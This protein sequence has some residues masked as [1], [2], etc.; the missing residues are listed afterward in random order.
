MAEPSPQQ[1]SPA[2][3]SSAPP[4]KAPIG[5]AIMA[6]VIAAA[7]LFLHLRAMIMETQ[8]DKKV[9]ALEA[10]QTGNDRA[11][12]RLTRSVEV[13]GNAVTLLSDEQAD[14]TNSKL[15]H[16]RHGFAVSEL[17][18]E[19]QDTGVL[20]EGR[21]INTSSLR[22]RDATFRV[23]VGNSSKEITIGNL[24]PGSSS[25]FEAVLPNLALEN[26]RTASFSLVSSA[27]EYGR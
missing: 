4:S 11:Q 26:A 19:R 18:L 17:K 21:M 9:Q 7:A 2:P 12:G 5:I 1:E 13:L 15:Q 16:L 14:L 20:V 23:K 24:P 25:A 6:L 3:F 27:V 8:L 22:Y 10:S